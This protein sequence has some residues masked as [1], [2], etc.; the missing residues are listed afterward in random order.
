MTIKITKHSMHKK[1]WI[2]LAETIITSRI[3]QIATFIS[4]GDSI[5]ISLQDDTQINFKTTEITDPNRENG[6]HIA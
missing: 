3:Y 1:I 6:H 2:Y 4:K 5:N